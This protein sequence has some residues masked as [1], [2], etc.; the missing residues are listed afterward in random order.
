MKKKTVLPDKKD[1]LRNI[2]RC[3]NTFLQKKHGHLNFAAYS[4]ITKGDS[5]GKLKIPLQDIFLPIDFVKYGSREEEKVKSAEMIENIKNKVILAN[6]GFGKTTFLRFALLKLKKNGFVPVYW[7]WKYFHSRLLDVKNLRGILLNYFIDVLPNKKFKKKDVEE[8]VRG[9]RFIFLIDGFDEVELSS[10]L[11]VV[12]RSMKRY[13]DRYPKHS[14]VIASRIANYPEKNLEFFSRNG[15]EHYEICPLPSFLVHQYINN[16]FNFQFSGQPIKIAEKIKF[17][18]NYVENQPGIRALA[19]HPLLLSLI[20]LIYTF[21]GSLPDT[22][23]NLY[24]RCIELLIYVWKK[25]EKDIKIFEQFSLDNT[26]ISTLLTEIAY[27]FFEKFLDGEVKAF[28]VL[29]GDDLKKI[30]KKTYPRLTRRDEDS[31]EISVVVKRLFDYFKNSTGVIV[32]LSPGQYGFSHLTLLE[33][34]AAQRIVQEKGDYN[35][36][37]DYIVSLLDKKE[38]RNVEEVA[39]FQVELLSKSTARV[40]FID[41]LARRLL[42]MYRHENGQEKKKSILVLLAKLMRDNQDFSIHDAREILKLITITVARDPENKELYNLLNDIFL[43]SGESREHF[44]DLIGKSAREREIWENFSLRTGHRIGNKVFSIRSDINVLKRELKTVPEFKGTNRINQKIIRIEEQIQALNMILAEYREFAAEI[45]VL[46][47]EYGLAS[48]MQELLKRFRKAY[49]KIDI[50]FTSGAES[51]RVFTDKARIAQILEELIENS[52]K[53]ANS[54]LL[55]IELWVEFLEKKFII[56][57]RDNGK[58]IP[59]HLKV[60]IFEPFFS[61]DSKSTGIG[62]ANV[63]KNVESLNGE[64]VETG[65][66]GQGVH[67]EISFPRGQRETQ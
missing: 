65:L 67:F 22:K 29:P 1:S 24:E 21:E 49:P 27:R 53:Y 39:V 25:S 9:N 35:S 3:Y 64:I 15:F 8:F 43:L 45:E 32:E 23:V 59:G 47:K 16:F 63:K 7:E 20:A 17:L 6:P 50:S 52:I 57:L 12:Q 40:P 38:F 34:L 14:F 46:H 56:H 61:T 18:G 37:L 54:V 11:S 48:M 28:G 13:I 5:G 2:L 41:L 66:E 62:L 36:N 44:V 55:R 10:E 30:L 4:N 51:S 58:G 33:Y 19:E 31:K 60:D 42:Y 26:T